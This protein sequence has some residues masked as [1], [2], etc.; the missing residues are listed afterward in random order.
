M[1]YPK[2]QRSKGKYKASI[3]PR[4]KVGGQ[5][6]VNDA[7]AQ[8][9][10]TKPFSV[11]FSKIDSDDFIPGS[12]LMSHV[13]KL[14]KFLVGASKSTSL[15]DFNNNMPME[16][17]PI[18]NTGVY[19]KLYKNVGEDVTLYEVDITDHRCVFYADTANKVVYL[20][21]LVKHPE[22]KKNYR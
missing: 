9:N 19:K 12:L 22:S 13:G 4:A 7:I 18:N 6:S 1:S 11:S 16:V 8:L 2:K 21:E 14:I 3:K 5:I 17:K 10:R 15:N 20:L